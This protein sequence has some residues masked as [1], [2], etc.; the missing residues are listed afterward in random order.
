MVGMVPVAKGCSRIFLCLIGCYSK[1]Q[2]I[3][4]L[5]V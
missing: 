1:V 4:G 3:D 5:S 2:P